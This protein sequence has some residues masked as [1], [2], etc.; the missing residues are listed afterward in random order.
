MNPVELAKWQWSDYGEFHGC[1]SNLWIHIFAVPLFIA[2][3]L[4]A[5]ILPITSIILLVRS[6]S[7]NG[8]DSLLPLDLVWIVVYPFLGLVISLAAISVQGSGHKWE[9]KPP[10][11]FSSPLNGIGRILLEQWWTFP[12]FV[13]SGGW[14]RALRT[15]K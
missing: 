5:L 9:T 3:N 14:M 7:I 4:L 10:K 13:F 2:G 11:P 6:I 8:A 15:A 12:R 1:K